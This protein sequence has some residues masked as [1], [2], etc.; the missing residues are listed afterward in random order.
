MP[1]PLGELKMFDP[2]LRRQYGIG[3]LMLATVFLTVSAAAGVGNAIRRN[4]VA[5]E[6]V[7]SSAQCENNL[8]TLG[9][10][11]VIVTDETVTAK[12]DG[13]SDGYAQ[14][15]G[16]SAGAMAC[17]GWVMRTFCMGQECQQPGVLM[18]LTKTL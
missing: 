2:I 13:L 1:A 3:A 15:G 8:K 12:W 17:Q 9:A 11:S 14:L 16:A 10:D 4:S 7:A 18:T 5:E 6:I